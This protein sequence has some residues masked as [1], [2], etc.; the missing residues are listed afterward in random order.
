MKAVA[1][2]FHRQTFT[3]KTVSLL[4][5]T[6][7]FTA[8]LLAGAVLA[9]VLTNDRIWWHAHFSV[10]GGGD[11]LSSHIFNGTLIAGG[12]LLGVISLKFGS[13][14]S[15]AN[16]KPQR[17]VARVIVEYSF[18]CMGVGMLVAGLVP[19]DVFY[20]LHFT[21]ANIMA[22][23]FL[24]LAVCLRP[25][26][27]DIS[28]NALFATYGATLLIILVY[29]VHYIAHKINMTIMEVCIGLL[30]FIWLELFTRSIL[31]LTRPQVS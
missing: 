8:V 13:E 7:M 21:A 6:R 29:A 19:Y 22:A 4:F 15:R 20:E 2:A 25:A 26:L 31:R 16:L 5:L 14:L 24:L 12:I 10:L 18:M 17:K 30:F 9:M 3:L 1:T 27:P 23:A 11:E 28:N